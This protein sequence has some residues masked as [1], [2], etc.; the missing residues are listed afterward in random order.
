M[1]VSQSVL[2]EASAFLLQL[3]PA[4]SLQKHKCNKVET[5][6]SNTSIL[7]SALSKL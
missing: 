6:S 3:S 7:M 5:R 4:G 1:I 2:F